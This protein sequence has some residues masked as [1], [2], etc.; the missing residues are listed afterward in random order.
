MPALNVE[1]MPQDER[2]KIAICGG[3]LVLKHSIFKLAYKN[4]FNK[5]LKIK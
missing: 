3:G 1:N 4:K 5:N 2:K